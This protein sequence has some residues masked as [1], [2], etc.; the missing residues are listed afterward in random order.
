MVVVVE[1]KEMYEV[2]VAS[3]GEDDVK[4]EEGTADKVVDDKATAARNSS[5]RGVTNVVDVS[6]VESI[7]DEIECTTSL[8]PIFGNSKTSLASMPA[9]TPR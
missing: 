6:A 8:K 3:C 4:D 2:T 7:L 5:G 9:S 1:I